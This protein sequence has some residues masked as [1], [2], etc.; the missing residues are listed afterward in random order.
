MSSLSG[1]LREVVAYERTHYS[2]QNFDFDAR[3]FFFNPFTNKHITQKSVAVLAENEY[4]K[5]ITLI[6][7]L[8]YGCTNRKL[9]VQFQDFY[10]V[11]NNTLADICKIWHQLKKS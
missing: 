9:L 2:T 11:Q 10:P 7:T 8:Y 6:N 5:Y 4:R 3:Y 1:P